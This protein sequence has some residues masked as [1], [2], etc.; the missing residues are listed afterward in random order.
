MPSAP[1]REVKKIVLKQLTKF[2]KAHIIHREYSIYEVLMDYGLNEYAV[3]FKAMG[4][5]TRLNILTMLTKG[6][7]CACK[8]LEAFNFT[9]PTLSYHMKQLTDCGLVDGRK[10]GK[11]VYYSINA[12]K[13]GLLQE[14]MAAVNDIKNS[15]VCKC[16]D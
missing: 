3:I 7:T 6:E 15:A 4:D 16:C 5:E 9:Q 14:F 12:E 1:F 10:E 11:W 13:V 8:L 2:S